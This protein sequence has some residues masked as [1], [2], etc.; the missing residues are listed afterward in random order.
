MS[1]PLNHLDSEDPFGI[2]FI[3]FNSLV[4]I[5]YN[6]WEKKLMF[7]IGEV[8]SFVYGVS[9][10]DAS[11]NMVASVVFFHFL[12]PNRLPSLVLI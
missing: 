8:L 10:A 6:T 1:D 4:D 12:I 5:P 11:Y 7:I 2:I 3:H 9:Q